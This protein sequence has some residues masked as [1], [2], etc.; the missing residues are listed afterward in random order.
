MK[1][2]HFLHRD[3]HE[4]CLV[5]TYDLGFGRV[6]GT[7]LEHT[8]HCGLERLPRWLKFVVRVWCTWT[9]GAVKY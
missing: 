7:Y 4:N 6:L 3:L 1:R 5:E 2:L 9:L 8:S